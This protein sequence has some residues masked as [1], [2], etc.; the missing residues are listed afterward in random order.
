MS[1][2]FI[3]TLSIGI[4]LLVKGAVMLIEPKYMQKTAF[5]FLR[6]QV[7]SILLFGSGLAW[8]LWHVLNLGVA[9]FGEYRLIL[10]A[11]FGAAGILSFFYVEDF[12]SVRGAAILILLLADVVLDTAYM[13]EP[14]SRLFLVGFVYFCIVLALYIGALPYRL[15][16]MLTWI[17]NN[18]FRSRVLGAAT[19]LYGLILVSVAFLY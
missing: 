1:P 9:D 15:R 14:Q 5:W 7:A 6:S 18:R 3:A 12:L 13:Q 10:F 2:L 19:A 4:I 16:D 11:I 8:F 17:Y